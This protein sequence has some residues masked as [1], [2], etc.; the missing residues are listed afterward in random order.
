MPQV[1]GL[2][3]A[4][5]VGACLFLPVAHVLG[6]RLWLRRHPNASPQVALI[7]LAALI[8]MIISAI[9]IWRL[10]HT[11]TLPLPEVAAATA[12][13]LLTFATF[14]YAYFHVFN[15]SETGRRIRILMELKYGT[16]KAGNSQSPSTAAD[17]TPRDMV[18]SRLARL[19]QMGQIRIDDGQG[20]HIA[21]RKFL[22]I[23]TLLHV[24]GVTLLGQ[25][26]H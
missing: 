22:A 21:G 11:E 8:A 5:T 9:L 15:L 26:R 3:L 16:P 19:R 18:I 24:V 1:E 13:A 20:Y 7:R 6:E 10:P 25:N 17:Y 4:V 2:T 23:G 12:Y 14:A